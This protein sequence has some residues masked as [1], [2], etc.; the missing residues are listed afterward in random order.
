MAALVAIRRCPHLRDCAQRIIAR[1]RPPKV[2]ITAVMRK[3]VVIINAV[4]AS[5]QPCRSP[6]P[7]DSQHGRARSAL[8]LAGM[9]RLPYSVF[10]LTALIPGLQT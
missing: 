5:Q 3:L 7:L 4:L 6:N 9:T 8:R 2:A 10:T 1:R